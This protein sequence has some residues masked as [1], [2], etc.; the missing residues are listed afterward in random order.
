MVNCVF[1]KIIEGTEKAEIYYQDDQAIIFKDIRP[2]ASHHFLVVPKTHIK[3]A[4][5]LTPDQKPIGK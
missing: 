2:A 5:I 1:C 4:K 3:N